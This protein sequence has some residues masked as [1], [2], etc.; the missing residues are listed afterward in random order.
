MRHAPVGTIAW[1]TA[2]IALLALAACTPGSATSSPTATALASASGSAGASE[3]A[4]PSTEPSAAPS[5]EPTDDLP[6]FS[7]DMP[8]SGV[9]TVAIAHLL[10]VR[11]GE[12][13]GFD[14]VVFEFDEG[15]PAFTID[16]ASPP[17]TED[18]SGLPL[19]VEGDAFWS[20]RLDGGTK[21]GEDGG[22]TYGG[23]TDFQPD[24][25]QLVHL[26]EGG[27]FEAVSTWYLGLQGETCLR[28]L[29]LGD[30]ARLVID[31][32]H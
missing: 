1:A 22:A 13:P 26:T 16:D 14:R 20:L 28:V 32:E 21:Q 29:T 19:E 30:P 6:D 24:F 12:H 27:D 15:I 7:C 9:G 25:E 8:T 10:D 3:T 17:F 23:P 4:A 18:A 5:D 11:V 31:I 2:L